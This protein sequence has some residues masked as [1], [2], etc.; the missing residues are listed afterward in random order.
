[1]GFVMLAILAILVAMG[2]LAGQTYVAPKFSQF[3]TLQAT[4]AGNIAVTALF[5]FAA[6][7]VGGFL[8]SMVTKEAPRV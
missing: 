2:L 1:M 3:K 6:M 5:I 8:L 7:L 4:Y